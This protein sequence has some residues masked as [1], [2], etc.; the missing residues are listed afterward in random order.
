MN[1]RRFAIVVTVC[2]AA[3]TL[4][5][6]VRA[7]DWP[8]YKKDSARSSVTTEHLSLPLAQRWVYRPSQPPRPAWPEP[9]KELNRTDFD[10]AFQTVIAGGLVYFGSSADDTVRALDAKTGEPVW[11]FTTG[12]PVRFAPAVARG[13]LYVASDDGIL[14][15]L[16][17]A[18][19]TPIWQFSAEPDRDRVIGNG[20]L[21]ARR[22][23][24]S[25]A[26]V[27]DDVVYVTAG[28]WPTEGV[29]VF[30][31]DADTGK[32]LWCNDS[33]GNIYA[34]L[35]HAFANGFSG[36][37]P[38]GYLV[39]SQDVLIVPTGR[40]VPAAFDR[41]TGRLLHY[42]PEKT[43]YQGASYGG[44]VWCTAN[45]DLYFN[46]NNRSQNPSEAFIGEADPSKQDGMI[47]YPLAT[48]DQ[49]C[50]IPGKYRVLVS[51]KVV[52]AVGNGSIEAIDLK[53]LRRK[54]RISP[55]DAKWTTPH[56]ARV[57]CLAM[58]GGTLLTGNRDSIA[59][60]SATDGK[61]VWRVDLKDRQ[62]RAM[63]VADGRLVAGMHTGEILCFGP[64]EG[65]NAE[66]RQVKQE[67]LS[68]TLLDQQE[69][70]AKTVVERSGKSEGYALLVGE[71][72]VRLA[73]ALAGQTNLHVVCLFTDAAQVSAQRQRLLDAGLLGSRVAI[74]AVEEPANLHLPPY[75]ADLIVVSGPTH[76]VSP[77]QCYRAL[78]PCGGAICSLDSTLAARQA[79][80]ARANIP[81]TEV[82]G[83]VVVRGQLPG[84][85]EW[86]YPWADGGT[87]GHRQRKPRALPNAI[88]LVRRSRA[89]AAP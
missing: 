38:Q 59:A 21:I 44:G 84:A 43:H 74:L 27:V 24:R 69:E 37:A 18:T 12:G 73:E 6:S 47:V 65:S 2:L 23:C 57:Y 46:T 55:K 28:M 56:P 70:R 5:P 36:V 16:D 31:L 26:L 83:P 4:T 58:A 20:R 19:G 77:E 52:Y 25:G 86:R 54:T 14:Y 50:H 62:V 40:S 9:G 78:R 72:D 87:A 61:P 33:S 45:R 80:I 15:C 79:F 7:E 35:P 8:A 13:K 30:A 42:K 82:K 51:G 32:E 29:S 17:A 76:V 67:P 11:R 85:G 22:P 1:R 66:P 81:S 41:H 60:F 48:G 64:G 88:A 75:F 89:G 71:P 3:V 34:D 63:A 39:V 68:S 53:T 49:L 10:Y